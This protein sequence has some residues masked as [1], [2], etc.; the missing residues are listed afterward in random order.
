MTILDDAVDS[1]ILDRTNGVETMTDE[2]TAADSANAYS[3]AKRG[4]RADLEDRFFRSAWEANYARYLNFLKDS[5]EITDWEYE[6]ETFIFHGVTR[7]P[8]SYLPDF[9]VIENDGS[10]VYHEIKG[11]MDSKSKSKLRRMA[12]FYP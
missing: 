3:R 8:L 7:N 5:H 1:E 11:W 4:R 9:K 10:V 6:P 12:K 2:T